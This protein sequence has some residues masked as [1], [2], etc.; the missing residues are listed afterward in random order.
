MARGHIAKVDRAK[1][2][3]VMVDIGPD[4]ATGK[5][6]QRKRSFKT[7]RDAEKALAA[8]LAEIDRGEAMER[9]VMTVRDLM[10]HWLDDHV[11]PTLRPRT[12]HLYTDTVERHIIPYLGHLPVQTL[13]PP[14][15]QRFYTE[16]RKAGVSEWALDGVHKRLSQALTVAMKQGIV[17]RNV[18]ALVT[19]PRPRPTER[20]VWDGAQARRFLEVAARSSYGALWPLI[21]STGLRPGEALA[22]RWRDL[23]QD[24]GTLDVRQGSTERSTVGDLVGGTTKTP[25]GR[26]MVH[27]RPEVVAALRA[28]H[29]AQGRA[30]ME[31][32]EPYEDNGLVFATKSGKPIAPANLR[33]AFA[34]LIVKA[35][36]PRIR[37]YDARHT[38]ASI[39]LDIGLPLKAVSE[40]MGHADVSTTLRTYAHVSRDQRARVADEVGG[41]LFPADT[42]SPR[43]G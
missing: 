13:T 11:A 31:R 10:R 43:R 30:R 8:W 23:H 39:A 29:S 34:R 37:L 7:K 41:V 4:P 9:S 40:S 12:L 14:V 32:G 33:H 5:R 19:S 17:Q 27:L 38:Y 2:W 25:T 42:D 16:R 28:Y 36:V 26:R 21:L 3:V 6:R 24:A 35:G 18:C 1:P 22:L 20:A 15:V